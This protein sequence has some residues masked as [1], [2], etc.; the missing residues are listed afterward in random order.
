MSFAMAHPLIVHF[1]MALLS[2]GAFFRLFGKF[3]K[4]ESILEA[5][6]FNLIF[7]FW[8]LIPALI[9]GL[10]GKSEIEIKPEFQPFIDSHLFYAF[11]SFG[12]FAA[13]VII[14]RLPKNRL[15]GFVHYLFCFIGLAAILATG[16]YG[17]ELVHRFDLPSFR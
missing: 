9:I 14:E 12:F 17:G 8:T 10:L 3:Q 4:E 15:T 6:R 2:S 7:G 13:I 1:P 11:L 5:G 16:F